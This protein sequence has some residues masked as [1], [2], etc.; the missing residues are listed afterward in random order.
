MLAHQ[1]TCKQLV[2]RAN[3]G[4]WSASVGMRGVPGSTRGTEL[5]A[6]TWRTRAP[7]AQPL[8]PTGGVTLTNALKNMVVIH[9]SRRVRRL[10]APQARCP[11][12]SHVPATSGGAAMGATGCWQ[13]SAVCS[14]TAPPTVTQAGVRV[15][16]D[17]SYYLQRQKQIFVLTRLRI[18][19]THARTIRIA[20]AAIT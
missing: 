11:G 10:R 9:D 8:Q 1:V 6:R 14:A 17:A 13:G 2:A 5:G 7:R 19:P 15:T 4:C 20:A 16:R 3:R 12:V 18:A